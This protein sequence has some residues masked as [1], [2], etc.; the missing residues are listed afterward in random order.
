MEN[1]H[2]FLLPLVFKINTWLNPNHPSMAHL[3]ACN[4]PNVVANAI[5]N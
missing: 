3:L 2:V 1:C 4:Y 5:T